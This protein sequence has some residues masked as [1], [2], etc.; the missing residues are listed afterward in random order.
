[1]STESHNLDEDHEPDVIPVESTEDAV[2]QRFTDRYRDSLR[3][4]AQWAE[5]RRWNGVYWQIDT[6][7][8]V[9]DLVRVF[10]REAARTCS[11]QRFRRRLSSAQFVAAV[12]K[13]VRADQVHAMR[14]EQWDEDPWLLN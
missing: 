7:L 3:Y 6:T 1:M 14:P 9:F 5:W 8:A 10:C 13:L 12:E 2:A 4:T 11:S